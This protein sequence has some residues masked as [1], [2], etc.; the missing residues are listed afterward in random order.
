MPK[1]TNIL[2]AS[3]VV[4]ALAAVVLALGYL[5]G[6]GTQSA[7]AAGKT[8]YDVTPLKAGWTNS[9]ARDINEKQQ[10]AGQGTNPAGQARAFLWEGRT[11]TDLGV[12]AGDDLSRARGINEDGAVVGEWR[13]LIDGQQRFKAFVYEGGQMKDLN[14]LIPADSG[15][16][17][18]GAQAINETG[19]IVGSG[20]IN[21][22]THAFLYE[23]GVP[24]DLGAILGDPYSAAWGV[25]DLGDVVGGTGS[26][27]NLSEA[28]VYRDGAVDTL[29]NLGGFSASEAVGI[30]NSGQAVGWSF[31]PGQN[32][33]QGKAFLYDND[34]DGEA[35]IVPL[36]PLSDDV[37]SRARDID[38]AGRVV[39]W[40]RNDAAGAPLAEQFSAALWED[41]QVKDLNDLIPAESGWKLVDAYAINGSGQIVGSGFK[42]GLLQAFLLNPVYDFGGFFAPV[43]NPPTVNVVKA[44]RAIPVRFSL[45]GDQGLGV[46]EETYPRSKRVPC[47]AAPVD[48]IEETTAAGTSVLTYDAASDEYTY[49]WKT[50]KV[51]ARTCRQL[52][53]KLDDGTYHRVKFKFRR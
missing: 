10:I 25:N 20:T 38:E 29:D 49:V 1:V 7:G 23:D 35:K 46:F 9:I 22:E 45:S 28:F 24:T 30:N 31:N 42:D 44:G 27:A 41:G 48:R 12:P 2:G 26:A 32:P 36:E 34:A 21:G 51:W 6:V 16:D 14:G 53:M 39:G 19:Q 52:T 47:K 13:V 4:T 5:V 37:Y 17:L 40:S 43:D 15:W 3:S 50:K 8:L 11:V 18:T 33:P